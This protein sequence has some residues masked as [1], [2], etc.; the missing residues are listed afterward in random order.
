[1]AA[2]TQAA[3]GSWDG[4][5]AGSIAVRDGETFRVRLLSTSHCLEWLSH[6]PSDI[7]HT[8]LLR[9]LSAQWLSQTILTANESLLLANYSGASHAAFGLLC[10]SC[11]EKPI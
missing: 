8:G 11:G 10:H 3:D 5:W 7:F 6:V 4:F 1:M 9:E 2:K